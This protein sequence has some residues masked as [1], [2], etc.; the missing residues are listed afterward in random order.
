[1]SPILTQ[2][3]MIIMTCPGWQLATYYCDYYKGLIQLP[4]TG[5]ETAFIIIIGVLIAIW[6]QG[7]LYSAVDPVGPDVGPASA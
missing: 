4:Y 7:E 2:L 5:R 6:G 1:M 3:K